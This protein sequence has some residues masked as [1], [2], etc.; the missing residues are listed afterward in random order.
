MDEAGNWAGAAISAMVH[1][2]LFSAICVHS[3]TDS[4]L[5]RCWG[6]CQLYTAVLVIVKQSVLCQLSYSGANDCDSARELQF[7]VRLL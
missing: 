6:W 1:T 4:L 2:L 7:K 5:L 3:A